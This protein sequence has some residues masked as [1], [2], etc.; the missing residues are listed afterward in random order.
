MSDANPLPRVGEVFFDD[1]GEDRA[2]RLSWHPDAQVMVVS[3]WNGGVCSGTFRLS[4]RDVPGFIE[5]MSQGL[6]SSEPRGRRHAGPEPGR[7]DGQ[8]QQ[9]G[10]PP[11]HDDGPGPTTQALDA[12]RSLSS[13]GFAPAPAPAPA[14]GYPQQ[15]RHRQPP[16]PQPAPAHEQRPAQD[17]LVRDQWA[18]QERPY[19]RPQDVPMPDQP[20]RYR[21]PPP[22][23]HRPEAPP[24]PGRQAPGPHPQGPQQPRPPMPGPNGGQH[25]PP[26]RP[27]QP[28]R[29][30]RPERPEWPAGDP[31]QEEPG[32]NRFPMTGEYERRPGGHREP[33][34]RPGPR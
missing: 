9:A 7:P 23:H 15:P 34:R 5:S 24:Y 31:A 30:E 17:P 10:P 18:A 14:P 25:R 8:P 21:Q 13:P 11:E 29:P 4:A 33:P 27:E 28:P 6:P 2:L 32:Q 16:S 12:L 19:G 22:D 20:T 3:I 26:Y 1:R